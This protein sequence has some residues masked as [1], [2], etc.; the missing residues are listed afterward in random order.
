MGSEL[1][2]WNRQ[3]TPLAGQKWTW[4]R[5]ALFRSISPVLL[6]MC[7]CFCS[8]F[9]LI[10]R[11]KFSQI[12]VIESHNVLVC[13]NGRKNKLRVYYLSWLRNKILRG[14]DDVSK[15]SL[16]SLTLTL[17]LSLTHS[18]THL[19]TSPFTHILILSLHSMTVIAPAMALCLLVIWSTAFTIVCCSMAR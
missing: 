8:V 7:I 2:S 3:W 1:V 18:L 13:I 19:L 11:R 5:W 15:K 14:G 16:H 6:H 17:S 9:P 12:E 4:Q 10:S